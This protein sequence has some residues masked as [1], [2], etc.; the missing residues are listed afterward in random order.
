MCALATR[1]ISR[2]SGPRLRKHVRDTG[3]LC[4]LARS[5][6]FRPCLHLGSLGGNT[7]LDAARRR[8]PWHRIGVV[9]TSG[10]PAHAGVTLEKR[11]MPMKFSW[12]ACQPNCKGGSSGWV[13][14]VG[15]V[16][17]DTPGD[18]DEFARAAARWRDHRAGFQR[19]FSQRSSE[20]LP[21]VIRSRYSRSS[22]QIQIHSCRS[23]CL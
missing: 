12:V 14:A 20:N 19:W 18:F 9:A 1:P 7:R 3:V 8:R 17:A 2:D 11:K 5:P 6:H 4:R 13:N 22:W 10:D 21:S 15:I 16:T 23:P